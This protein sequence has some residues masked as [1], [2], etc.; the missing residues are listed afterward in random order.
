MVELA[1]DGTRQPAEC[2][3]ALRSSP[4]F[5]GRTRRPQPGEA[6]EFD[7]VNCGTGPTGTRRA[8]R[9]TS[10][11]P[12][13]PRRELRQ[14]G[15]TGRRRG[16]SGLCKAEKLTPQLLPH[17]HFDQLEQWQ[18]LKVIAVDDD[19][20]ETVARPPLRHRD[21][22]YLIDTAMVLQSPARRRW[23]RSPPKRSLG[24]PGPGT[25]QLD[26]S[27]HPRELQFRCSTR[28]LACTST[29]PGPSSGTETLRV[30]DP[31]TTRRPECPLGALA[32]DSKPCPLRRTELDRQRRQRLLGQA[33]GR[34]EIASCT[35]RTACRPRSTPTCGSSRPRSRRVSTAGA[36]DALGTPRRS[37]RQGSASGRRREQRGVPRR[38]WRISVD[39]PPPWSRRRH[40]SLGHGGDIQGDD[41]NIR[42]SRSP[43]GSARRRRAPV[44]LQGLHAPKNPTTAER[45][46]TSGHSRREAEQARLDLRAM[47]NA[48]ATSTAP[49][50][51]ATAVVPSPATWSSAY[52]RP[53]WWRPGTH[54]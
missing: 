34:H 23:R 15:C 33:G 20:D 17:V 38:R 3:E 25:P 51:A 46:S 10:C 21:I 53:T 52:A 1:G 39:R 9:W 36:I 8:S 26:V 13:W 42:W 12:R 47:K 37:Q 31:T 50:L 49:Y 41:V 48:A 40:H 14:G 18:T 4:S 44:L 7:G 16:G 11:A 32:T 2:V 19:E 27:G 6:G 35:T 22:G 54:R 45:P 29:A 43:A 24:H 30:A 28:A 5:W